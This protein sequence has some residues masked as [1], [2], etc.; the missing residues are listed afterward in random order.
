MKKKGL[1]IAIILGLNILLVSSFYSADTSGIKQYSEEEQGSFKHSITFSFMSFM[2]G[3]TTGL[4]PIPLR[5]VL[6]FP[7]SQWGLILNNGFMFKT[8]GS[9][10]TAIYDEVRVGPRYQL[11]G[12]GISGMYVT[13][14]LMIGFGS[15]PYSFKANQVNNLD[16]TPTFLYGAALETGYTLVLDIGFTVEGAIGIGYAVQSFSGI[17]VPDKWVPIFNV[18]VGW[19]F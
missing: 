7:N 14:L 2:T 13:P 16:P 11:T 1:L 9:K 10:G 6:G 12:T 8:M 15:M 18:G 17:S 4:F 3:I 19:T 5:Y